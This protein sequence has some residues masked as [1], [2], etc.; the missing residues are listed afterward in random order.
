MYGHSASGIASGATCTPLAANAGSY[1][2]A[3]T[4]S[5]SSSDTA[6][7]VLPQSLTSATVLTG[8]EARPRRPS[9]TAS[10]GAGS[11]WARGEA[12]RMRRR[13]CSFSRSIGLGVGSGSSASSPSRSPSAR[14]TRMKLAVRDGWPA[15][16]RS[17]VATPIPASRAS[18]AWVMLRSSRV[19]EIRRP[20]SAR[21][22]SSVFWAE[23]PISLTY[24]G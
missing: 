3:A 16:I 5:P 14:R 6:P 7:I 9:A 12:A 10:E 22:V 21:T 13:P 8:A 17:R 15:S 24:D 20:S 4:R 19:R 1:W 2:N 23:I 11:W 18:C